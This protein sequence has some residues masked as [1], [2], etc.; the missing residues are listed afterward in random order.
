MWDTTNHVHAVLPNTTNGSCMDHQCNV[1]HHFPCTNNAVVPAA[2]PP[3][4]EKCPTI[5]NF[6]NNGGM[7]ISVSASGLFP[8]FLAN[9][10]R[11]LD[12]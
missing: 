6:I 12:A 9:F 10:E 3:P 11:H 7:V 1:G 2:F 5:V 4:E 8:N